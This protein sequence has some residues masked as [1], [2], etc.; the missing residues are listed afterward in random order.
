MVTSGFEAFMSEGPHQKR[1]AT[2]GRPSASLKRSIM[3]MLITLVVTIVILFTS[4]SVPAA[5]GT[6]AQAFPSSE[7][8]PG[9]AGVT[10]NPNGI[11]SLSFEDPDSRAF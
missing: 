5:G 1:G 7:Q 2:L 9:H 4:C 11:R 3:T 10:N 8:L 6:G